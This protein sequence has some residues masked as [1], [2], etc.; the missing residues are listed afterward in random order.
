[1]TNFK[2]IA[3]VEAYIKALR[4]GESLAKER[5]AELLTDSAKLVVNGTVM[6]EGKP[7]ILR[8]IAGFWPFTIPYGRAD[9]NFPE[10]VEGR[11]IVSADF[12]IHGAAPQ[13]TTLDFSFDGNGHINQIEQ[14]LTHKA[15]A[16]VVKTMP[17]DVAGTINRSLLVGAPIV[18][19]Y[20]DADG[21][22]SLSLRGGIQVYSP[23]Q[24]CMWVRKATGGLVDGLKR[25]PRVTMLCRES[26]SRTT[27]IIKAN[28]MIS[29]DPQV[30]ERVYH[31]MP[32]VEQNHD[33]EWKGVAAIFDITLLQ[34]GG[35]K[36]NVLMKP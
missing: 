16:E 29:D 14:T 36:G 11:Y 8:R 7:A 23:T 17:A 22:A 30:R 5:V 20:V 10:E 15:P 35:I 33:L 34:G 25:D 19:G 31:L 12:P 9:W 27:Y 13:S 28:G 6:A 24:L 2:K 26:P 1:M 32:E 21:A 3:G 4:T 18:L